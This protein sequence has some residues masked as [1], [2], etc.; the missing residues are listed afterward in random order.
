MPKT[1]SLPFLDKT[2]AG[3]KHV[4]SKA[5]SL[6]MLPNSNKRQINTYFPVEIS[7]SQPPSVYPY[8]PAGETPTTQESSCPNVTGWNPDYGMSQNPR[9]GTNAVFPRATLSET[10]PGPR[11]TLEGEPDLRLSLDHAIQPSLLQ[12]YSPDRSFPI[13]SFTGSTFLADPAFQGSYFVSRRD[14][15]VT[16]DGSESEFHPNLWTT[17]PHSLGTLP[18][19]Q[20]QSAEESQ[21]EEGSSPESSAS[22]DSRPRSSILDNSQARN[23]PLYSQAIPGFDGKWYCPWAILGFRNSKSPCEHEPTILKCNYE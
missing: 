6:T 19:P 5:E 17:N 15:L 18:L 9:L 10:S 20:D 1:A 4:R 11:V 3:T 12:D 2:A 22:D 13:G 23:D 21:D 8:F 7:P 14:R 16:Q